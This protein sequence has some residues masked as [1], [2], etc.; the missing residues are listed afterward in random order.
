VHAGIYRKIIAYYTA[1]AA[2]ATAT[3]VII[4]ILRRGTYGFHFG[5]DEL[6]CVHGFVDGSLV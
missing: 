2:F 5:Q 3:G 4:F 1:A 6:F